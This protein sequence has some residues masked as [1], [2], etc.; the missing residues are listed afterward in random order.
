MLKVTTPLPVAIEVWDLAGRRVAQV[1]AGQ[2]A[3][4]RHVQ[5]WDGRDGGGQLV[6]PGVYVCQIQMQTAQGTQT[7]I[8]PLTVAY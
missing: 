4:G 5:V 7:R 3:A 6:A 2:A 1:W 8:R